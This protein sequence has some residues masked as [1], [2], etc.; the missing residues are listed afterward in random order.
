MVPDQSLRSR[1]CIP[2][3]LAYP[4]GRPDR[5]GPSPSLL[6]ETMAQAGGWLIKVNEHFGV[7][8]IMSVIKGFRTHKT[9]PAYGVLQIEVHVVPGS[10]MLRGV[11]GSITD[12]QGNLIASVETILYVLVPVHDQDWVADAWAV[13]SGSRALDLQEEKR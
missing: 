13:L 4:A 10:D 3:T 8:A 1:T 6:L 7:L 12:A 11:A 5:G 9:P 2:R